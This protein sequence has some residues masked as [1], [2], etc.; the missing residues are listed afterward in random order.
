MD[1]AGTALSCRDARQRPRRTDASWFPEHWYSWRHQMPAVA[2]AGFRAA[3]VDLRGYNESDRPSR[4]AD[5]R[6]RTLV[7]DI[8]G[9]LDALGGGP[10]HLVAHDWGADTRGFTRRSNRNGSSR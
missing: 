9:F 6:L 8:D 2:D 5:Y 10:V 1:G 3:A 7:D 4:V